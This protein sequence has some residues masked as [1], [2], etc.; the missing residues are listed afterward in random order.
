MFQ[1]GNANTYNPSPPPTPDECNEHKKKS[2]SRVILQAS[3][4]MLKQASAIRRENFR[5]MVRL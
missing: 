5:Y 1:L 2:K 4:E 3:S